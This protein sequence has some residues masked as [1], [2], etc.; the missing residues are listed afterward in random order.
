MISFRRPTGFNGLVNRIAREMKQA[1][2][3]EM[4]LGADILLE[5]LEQTPVYTGRTLINYRFSLGSGIDDLR[6]PIARPQRP[7]KTSDLAVGMEPRRAANFAPVLAEHAAVKAALRRDPYQ[8]LY[9]TNNVPYFL[10]VEY[11]SYSTSE[12]SSVRTPPGGMMRRA[13]QTIASRVG[14]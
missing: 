3:D 1:V 7:G 10:D 12:G 4:R 13:E 2:S 14:G 5:H 9:L 8:V 11:G 6:A